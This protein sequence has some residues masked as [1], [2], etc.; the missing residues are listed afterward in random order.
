MPPH[1]T[2][3]I[4]GSLHTNRITKKQLAE[5]IGCTPEYVSMIL[6]GHRSPKGADETFNRALDELIQQ[7]QA[8]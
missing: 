7:K 6:N 8:V 1:W 2:A 4:V 5:Q 3:S